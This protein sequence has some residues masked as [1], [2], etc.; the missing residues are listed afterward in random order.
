MGQLILQY[1]KERTINKLI[2]EIGVTEPEKAKIGTIRRDYSLRDEETGRL[3]SYELARIKGRPFI[4]NLI[5]RSSSEEEAKR[6]IQLVEE[7]LNQL[8]AFLLSTP[9]ARGLECPNFFISSGGI[10]FS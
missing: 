1:T 2:G 7:L 4:Y 9:P 5:H 8:T 10:R 3:E 6:E